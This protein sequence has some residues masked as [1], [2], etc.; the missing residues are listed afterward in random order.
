MAAPEESLEEVL[1]SLR[2]Q[3]SEESR[4]TIDR[5]R[6]TFPVAVL[7]ALVISVILTTWGVRS[8]FESK[9]IDRFLKI[10]AKLVDIRYTLDQVKTKEDFSSIQEKAIKL[11]LLSLE[12]S[13]EANN[14]DISILWEKVK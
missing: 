8:F 5:Q 13:L 14:T 10:E 6:V 9:V 4:V 11:R 3:L 1:Q 7:V 12:N 2:D